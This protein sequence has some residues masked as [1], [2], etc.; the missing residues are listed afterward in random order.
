MQSCKLSLVLLALALSF[1]F[2]QTNERTCREEWTYV[3]VTLRVY[4][5][6]ENPSWILE[7]PITLRQIQA[8]VAANS[9]V[10][11]D[12]PYPWY[13]I[14]YS[15]FKLQPSVSS[16]ECNEVASRGIKIYASAYLERLLL[17]SGQHLPKEVVAH[18]EEE[19]AR[20]EK[21]PPPK[22]Y[23]LPSASFSQHK[24]QF[25]DCPIPVRGPDNSTVYN[26]D[27]DDCGMFVSHQYENN[28][29]DYGTDIVTNTYA[30]P[31]RGTGHKWTVNDCTN[32]AQAAESDG[33]KW[34]GTALPKD[35]I[36]R[37][38]GHY[39]ALFIWPQTNFHW[40]RKDS[41]TNGQWSHKPGGTPVRNVD[42]DGNIITDPSKSN[43]SPWTQFCGYMIAVPSKL[44]IS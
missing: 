12:G 21:D 16:S 26:P 20:L 10:Q 43:F 8:L 23:G 14:G 32:M 7:G 6:I 19:I 15:G 11:R 42:D 24:V 5:G 30:Q 39:V 41:N 4:S 29:Y 22:D 25:G 27:T 1:V 13:K 9:F 37:G 40:V 28:C 3:S 35:N 38:G 44:T 31:G 34:Y 17:A 36:P 2:A 33:L 18:V